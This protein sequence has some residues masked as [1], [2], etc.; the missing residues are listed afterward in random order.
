MANLDKITD[1]FE[2]T[3]F[4]KEGFKAVP[5]N[6]FDN[7]GKKKVKFNYSALGRPINKKDYYYHLTTDIGLTPSPIIN[8]SKCLWGAIDDDKHSTVLALL[9]LIPGA[10]V[11]DN[12]SNLDQ[13]L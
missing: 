13:V 3:F 9:N 2:Y 1:S 7:N 12:L 11:L 4:A 5:S 8:S 6:T 10:M